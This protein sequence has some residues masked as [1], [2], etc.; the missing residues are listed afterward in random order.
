[1]RLYQC[2]RVCCPYL[3]GELPFALLVTASAKLQ[4]QLLVISWGVTLWSTATS[5]ERLTTDTFKKYKRS[6]AEIKTARTRIQPDCTSALW[7]NIQVSEC[8][9]LTP[10]YSQLP[11]NLSLNQW[12]VIFPS[13]TQSD[14][15]QSEVHYNTKY[16]ELCFFSILFCC[17]IDAGQ[18]KRHHGRHLL[19]WQ[20]TVI[21]HKCA[22]RPAWCPTCRPQSGTPWC[23]SEWCPWSRLPVERAEGWTWLWNLLLHSSAPYEIEINAQRIAIKDERKQKRVMEIIECTFMALWSLSAK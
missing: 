11:H 19:R 1:M 5:H 17:W 16:Q 18:N 10:S 8:V 20:C 15:R 3:S 12:S 22:H 14:Y 23:G 7:A 21:S 13:W 4:Q 2:G 6:N 9:M